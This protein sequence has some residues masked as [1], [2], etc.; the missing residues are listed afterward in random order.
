VSGRG[1]GAATVMARLHF[2]IGAL[3]SGGEDPGEVLHKLSNQLEITTDGHFATVLCGSV[4]VERRTL[5]LAS[6]GHLPALMVAG[7]R[8]RFVSAPVGPPIGVVGGA[9]YGTLTV[10]VPPGAVLLAFTDGLVEEP[11]AGV[12]AGLERLRR[13]VTV[14]ERSLDGFL[15]T[16]VEV[17]IGSGP[18]DDTVVLAMRWGGDD[19]PAM[20][21]APGS[22]GEQRALPAGSGD[23]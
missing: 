12:A 22:A 10:D 8:R 19:G 11:E 6:A 20:S 23:R 15:D 4:D 9:R 18:A 17:V 7:G 21:A 13:E 5:T 1:I 16:M 2:A 14:G 3:A